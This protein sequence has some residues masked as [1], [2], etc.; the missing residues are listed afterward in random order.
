MRNEP[1]S[2][3]VPVRGWPAPGSNELPAGQRYFPNE[4]PSKLPAA[5]E[6]QASCDWAQDR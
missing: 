5:N 2:G 4:D 6:A 3:V 1:A